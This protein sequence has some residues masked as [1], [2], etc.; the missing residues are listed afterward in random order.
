MQTIAT[1]Q[2]RSFLWLGSDGGA[3]L[4][5]HSCSKLDVAFASAP[6]LGDAVAHFAKGGCDAPQLVRHLRRAPRPALGITVAG[7]KTLQQ[8]GR[9]AFPR[10]FRLKQ[11]L[12]GDGDT[13]GLHRHLDGDRAV[14]T[15]GPHG[16]VVSTGAAPLE[17]RHKQAYLSIS[18][19]R[20]H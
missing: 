10:G 3:T 18:I 20:G 1:T 13:V 7:G 6:A 12:D 16:C 5:A 15:V 9:C 19:K 17:I 11:L 14:S 2:T 8:L 4:Q